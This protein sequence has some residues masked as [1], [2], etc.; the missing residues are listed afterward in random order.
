MSSQRSTLV[1]VF[2]DRA[3]AEQAIERLREAGFHNDQLHY[4]GGN[5]RGGILSTIKNLFTGED[6]PV[7]QDITGEL[8]NMGIPRGEAEYYA[9]EHQTGH[10][11]VAIDAGDNVREAEEL[12]KQNGVYR[13]GMNDRAASIAAKQTREMPSNEEIQGIG[14]YSAQTEY[15]WSPESGLSN[16]VTDTDQNYNAP[17]LEKAQATGNPQSVSGQPSASTPISAS[18]QQN[19]S[20]YPD[21][22]SEEN[23]D[24]TNQSGEGEHTSGYLQTDNALRGVES[25]Q[26]PIHAVPD[27]KQQNRVNHEG[28]DTEA[29]TGSGQ[30]PDYTQ[31]RT[32][33][34]AAS[35]YPQPDLDQ[36]PTGVEKQDQEPHRESPDQ[37]RPSSPPEES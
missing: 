10:A 26:S 3:M 19:N 12:L 32:Q 2:H 25:T 31:V 28:F 17:S 21:N 4:S 18:A 33:G 9:H 13:Y 36:Q 22:L 7:S 23:E 37:A 6:Y 24:E 29:S 27:S 1:A 15:R 30:A 11:I 35:Y 14:D 8:E 34:D 20:G 16:D 5:T